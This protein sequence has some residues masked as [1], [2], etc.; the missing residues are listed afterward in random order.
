MLISVQIFVLPEGGPP[1]R[2][3]GL[4]M[5]SALTEKFM[6]EF[7]NNLGFEI[8]EEMEGFRGKPLKN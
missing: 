3:L 8:S 4:V 2:S 6:N 7:I 5:R 1:N